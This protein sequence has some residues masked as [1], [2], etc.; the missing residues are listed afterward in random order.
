MKSCTGLGLVVCYLDDAR[1]RMISPLSSPAL[2][3]FMNFPD[4]Y[5]VLT[6]CCL[7]VSIFDTKQANLRTHGIMYS[8]E[9]VV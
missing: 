4:E 9:Y 3:I 8:L 7:H 6:A 2:A 1:K 5:F